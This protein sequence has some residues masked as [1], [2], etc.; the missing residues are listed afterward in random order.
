MRLVNQDKQDFRENLYAFLISLNAFNVEKID[1]Q[2]LNGDPGRPGEDGIPGA[3]GRP[4]KMVRKFKI[5]K[6]SQTLGINIHARLIL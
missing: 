4:G 3:Q 5:G 1:I 2:G 6:F